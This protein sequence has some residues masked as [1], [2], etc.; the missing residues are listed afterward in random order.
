M[1][2]KGDFSQL[3]LT[4][5]FRRIPM[6]YEN[7][8][9]QHKS[10]ENITAINPCLLCSELLA[11][12]IVAQNSKF[13]KP[14]DIALCENCDLYYFVKKPSQAFL[15]DFYKKQ[16]FS[17]LKRSRL[18]YILKSRFSTM[19]AFS[20]FAYIQTYI[21]ATQGKKILE[22]GS[23]DGTFLSFFIKKEW[24]CKGL[25]F[26]EY[27]INKAHKKYGIVL[28]RTNIKDIDPGN[29]RFDIIA[30]SHVLEHLTDPI[31]I[32]KHCKKL[33]NP[34]GIVFIELPYSPLP[35][36]ISPELLQDYLNTTHLFNFRS[37]SLEKFLMKSDLE[38][39]SLDR[40][41]Y[42]VP[43]VFKKYSGITGDTLMKGR[44]SSY[45]PINIVP[46][47]TSV[48]LMNIRYFSKSDPMKKIPLEAKWQGLGDNLRV[49]AG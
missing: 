43:S 44:L 36:E 48:L 29:E 1:A 45:S 12:N 47:L 30:L 5:D 19:R 8:M 28:E 15:D 41:F 32:L 49:I 26:N 37:S 38:P 16:F 10:S 33:L 9:E 17:E 6:K 11:S 3:C 13:G 25:E 27:M 23:A 31:D 4:P 7:N 34:G 42:S 22:V 14:F 35:E 2:R 39:F 24:Y 20:Q 46:I 40:F 21:N 18:T